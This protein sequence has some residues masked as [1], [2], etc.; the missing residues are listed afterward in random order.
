MELE[1]G[2]SIVNIS[3]SH[4][5]AKVRAMRQGPVLVVMTQ[6]AKGKRR[7]TYRVNENLLTMEVKMTVPRLPGSLKYVASYVR[8]Q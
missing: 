2:G 7:T 3:G 8:I 6:S 4:G 1:L 5:E